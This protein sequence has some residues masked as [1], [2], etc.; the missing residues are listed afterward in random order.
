MNEIVELFIRH[1]AGVA[2]VVA[3]LEQIGAPIPALPVLVIAAAVAANT[4]GN[5]WFLGALIIAG[6]LLADLIWFL[7]GRLYGYRMIAL[8]CRFSLSPDSCVRRT[9][10]LYLRYGL[11]SL[12]VAKFVPGF[13][14]VAP[15]LAG[16]LPRIRFATFLLFDT[17]GTAIW[18]VSAIAVGSLFRNQIDYILGE[19]TEHGRIAGIVLSALLL[20][21]VLFK[22]W[23]RRRFYRALRMARISV[24]ELRADLAS[25][26]PLVI[27]DVRSAIEQEAD[28]GR[29]PGAMVIRPEEIE[30][31]LKDVAPHNDL[32]LYCT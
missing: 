32:V 5:L 21:F 22:W 20:L 4:G 23:Q 9:E 29:I 10:E 16:A 18:A 27:L 24:A 3:F 8:I 11:A 28:P 1:G 6:G 12:L 17:A 7:L 31:R 26:S 14:L 2:F 13:S 25:G 15:P 19:I 30:W